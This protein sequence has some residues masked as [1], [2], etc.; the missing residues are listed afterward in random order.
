MK[1]QKGED[2]E[3][4]AWRHSKPRSTSR[5]RHKQLGMAVYNDARLCILTRKLRRPL[6]VFQQKKSSTCRRKQQEESAVSA[7]A[8]FSVIL[9]LSFFFLSVF[10]RGRQ[11]HRCSYTTAASVDL[12]FSRAEVPAAYVSRDIWREKKRAN[13]RELEKYASPPRV[14]PHVEN[15]KKEQRGVRVVGSR[16]DYRAAISSGGKRRN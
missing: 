10:W 1:V 9:L 12:I 4:E 2:A 8:S 16:V 7:A 15:L 11:A 5:Q 3:G 14:T 6:Q 13:A